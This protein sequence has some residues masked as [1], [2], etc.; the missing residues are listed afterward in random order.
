MA[1]KPYWPGSMADQMLL[2]QNFLTKIPGYGTVLGLTPAQVTAAEALCEAF[3]GAVQ[4]TDLSKTSMQAMT[5]WRDE[6]LNG[7]PDSSAT[8]QAPVF[9]VVGPVTYPT[10]VV[11]RFAR[12]R[13]Q[14]VAAPGYTQA[15]GEDLG[16]VGAETSRPAPGSIVPELRA[17]TSTGYWV[18]LSGSMQGMDALKVEY[19]RDGGANFTTVTFLTNTPGGF[20]I[21]PQNPNLPEKGMV[22]AIFVKRNEEIGQYSANYPVTV[23]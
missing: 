8:P 16:I 17:E 18:N 11:K 22:R 6:I 2:V 13:D 12:L 4:A 3:I 21:T 23:S 7:D 15:I 10:G 1:R 14:I 5:Q 9:A 19:S 20:Q